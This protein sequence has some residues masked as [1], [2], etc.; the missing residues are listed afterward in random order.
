MLTIQWAYRAGTSTSVVSWSEN[1]APQRTAP[2]ML[3]SERWRNAAA[4]MVSASH[5]IHRLRRTAATASPAPVTASHVSGQCVGKAWWWTCP[6]V[7]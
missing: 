2:A 3:S 6:P 5:A 7:A 1:G 4:P